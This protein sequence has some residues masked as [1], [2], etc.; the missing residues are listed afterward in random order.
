MLEL[1]R[2]CFAGHLPGLV[3][4][5]F[6]WSCFTGQDCFTGQACFAGQA[7][8]TGQE[9]N[10]CPSSIQKTSSRRPTI[11]LQ[12]LEHVSDWSPTDVQQVSTSDQTMFQ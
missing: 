5:L 11:V 3:W 12:R 4:L 8:F 1:F 2:S 6:G 9:F 7:C 10:K